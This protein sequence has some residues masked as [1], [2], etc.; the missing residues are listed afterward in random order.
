MLSMLVGGLIRWGISL[1]TLLYE[2]IPILVASE[3]IVLAWL[4]LQIYSFD[5]IF[6][7]ILMSVFCAMNK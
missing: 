4:G 7:N 5:F 2:N 3:T 6:Q 1:K